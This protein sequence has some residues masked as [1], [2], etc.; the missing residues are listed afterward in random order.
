MLI[1]E[2]KPIALGD[3]KAEYARLCAL[4]DAVNE[5][6]KPLEDDLTAVNSQIET[7]RQRA[8]DI[9]AR[10]DDNR[11]RGNWMALKRDIG[12]LAQALSGKR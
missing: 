1:Y 4:R 3:F 2:S 11:G 9:A 5:Q 6:N 7:L 8:M 12:I 10:I